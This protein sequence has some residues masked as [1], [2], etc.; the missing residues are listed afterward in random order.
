MGGLIT[1]PNLSD[2]DAVY[3]RLVALHDGLDAIASLTVLARLTLLLV[4]HIGD[5]IVVAAAIDLARQAE[6]K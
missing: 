3:E 1:G 6:T 2:P 4:N 5:D